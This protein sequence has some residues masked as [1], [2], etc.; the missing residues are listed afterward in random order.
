MND[1]NN[2]KTPTQNDEAVEIKTTWYHR[3]IYSFL[4]DRNVK[5]I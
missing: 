1:N 5:R 2:K 3:Y 4:G